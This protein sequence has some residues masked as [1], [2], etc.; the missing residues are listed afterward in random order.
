[1]E[2]RRPW[3]SEGLSKVQHRTG[4]CFGQATIGRGTQSGVFRPG[5]CPLMLQELGSGSLASLE[6][7]CAVS[8]R[9]ISASCTESTA[10]AARGTY[11][12]T[13]IQCDAETN[14]TW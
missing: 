13:Q 8:G 10:G 11:P 9:A 2:L 3:M 6:H 7:L 14:A 5:R 1:M 4:P 12:S